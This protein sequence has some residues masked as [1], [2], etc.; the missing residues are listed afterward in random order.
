MKDKQRDGSLDEKI[1]DMVD[2]LLDDTDNDMPKVTPILMINNIPIASKRPSFNEIHSQMGRSGLGANR[3]GLGVPQMDFSPRE[4]INPGP[5]KRNSD[6]VNFPIYS[7]VQNKNVQYGSPNSSISI[8]PIGMN[9]HLQTMQ[10]R[11]SGSNQG[12]KVNYPIKIPQLNTRNLNYPAA[13]Q[14]QPQPSPTLTSSS[15][16]TFENY[17]STSSCNSTNSGDVAIKTRPKRHIEDGTSN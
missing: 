4:G 2:K 15:L 8:D 11:N 1:I 7:Q 12:G 10:T 5:N 9:M 14:F 13:G 6:G 17:L 16:R 3:L